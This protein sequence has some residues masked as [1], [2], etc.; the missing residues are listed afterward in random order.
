MA[1]T[2]FVVSVSPDGK[3]VAHPLSVGGNVTDVALKDIAG[4]H[5]EK[6]FSITNGIVV[7][8]SFSP[9]GGH[10]SVI[11]IEN[12]RAPSGK[13]VGVAYVVDL[14]EGKARRLGKTEV[15]VN[16]AKAAD[17]IISHTWVSKDKFALYSV[18]GG[19]L[20]VSLVDADGEKIRRIFKG[21][22][23]SA[24][25]P[26]P[27]EFAPLTAGWVPLG[28]SISASPQG[29]VYFCWKGRVFK[30]GPKGAELLMD[31]LFE[32]GYS[33]PQ[34]SPG[35]SRIA[36]YTTLDSPVFT[37]LMN[38]DA[39]DIA[40]AAKTPEGGTAYRG[41]NFYTWIEGGK[42]LAVIDH[43][44]L[45]LISADG[46]RRVSVP[47]GQFCGSVY[48]IGNGGVAL[49]SE[50]GL[51]AIDV[52]GDLA[53]LDKLPAPE[54]KRFKYPDFSSPQATWTTLNRACKDADTRVHSRCFA[55]DG[56]PGLARMEAAIGK[57][58]CWQ[59]LRQWP[60]LF[61]EQQSFV[62]EGDSAVLKCEDKQAGMS[63][64]LRFRRIGGE[65]KI[66]PET[67]AKPEAGK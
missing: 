42:Y 17:L 45:T 63:I 19:D 47:V 52:S 36:V 30:A 5:A 18:K 51:W 9:D 11:A 12:M 38:A 54:K 22:E 14:A 56:A 24:K 53:R 66:V 10:L 4:N 1:S 55:G 15:P 65:W 34:V 2:K 35:G 67:R 59:L 43:S 32:G 57:Q 60:L 27:A 49:L 29:E 25:W 48:G 61:P 16:F 39:T 50:T 3:K 7:G 31:N 8:L 64:E 23:A 58:R 26:V 21:S 20:E 28:E 62:V 46:S 6:V 33:S 41:G 40:V 13:P 37:C 44:R